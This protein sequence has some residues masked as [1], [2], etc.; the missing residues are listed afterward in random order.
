MKIEAVP[1]TDP[2]AVA[3]TTAALAELGRRYGGDGDSGPL[4]PEDLAPP[5]GTFLVAYVDGEPA[6]C[7]GWRTVDGM[8]GTAEIKRMYTDPRFYRRGV[9]TA[10]LRALEDSA[11]NAGM[12]RMVLETGTAQPEAM[13]LYEKAGYGRIEGFGYYADYPSNRAYA[14]DL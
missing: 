8:P 6:G 3:L 1:F 9:A 13:A 12:T 5:R 11:R 7:G 10:V 14:R 4:S 2:V